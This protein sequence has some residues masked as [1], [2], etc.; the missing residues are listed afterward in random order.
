MTLFDIIRKFKKEAE[1][2]PALLT[3]MAGMRECNEKRM[4][5]IKA[6]M[7]EKY[8]LHPVHLKTRLDEPRPV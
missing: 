4:E 7:G 8:I 1:P 3:Q 6:D 2:S 5:A